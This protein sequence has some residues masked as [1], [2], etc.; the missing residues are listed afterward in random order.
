[1]NSLPHFV[2]R[3]SMSIVFTL[4]AEG[5]TLCCSSQCMMPAARKQGLGPGTCGHPD[6]RPDRQPVHPPSRNTRTQRHWFQQSV[7]TSRGSLREG[8]WTKG[9]KGSN[10]QGLGFVS[11]MNS[12]QYSH[13][14]SI[15]M[16]NS[17]IMSTVIHADSMLVIQWFNVKFD[18]YFCLLPHLFLFNQIW[19]ANN[20]FN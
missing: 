1:M 3:S 13:G 11:T 19:N 10:Y 16:C 9:F 17:H 2:P 12:G 6:S 18:V 4:A 14:L 8:F 20:I 15:I 5:L 7:E